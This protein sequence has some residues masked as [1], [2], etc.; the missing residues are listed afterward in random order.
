MTL[1]LYFLVYMYELTLFVSNSN[2][3]FM[4]S[5]GDRFFK[6][7]KRNH[8]HTLCPILFTCYSLPPKENIHFCQVEYSKLR[9]ARWKVG[10]VGDP[11]PLARDNTVLKEEIE[12][13]RICK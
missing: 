5:L 7:M 1:R 12:C 6:T 10:Y 2:F 9:G 13:S 11:T 8:C 4:F 3:Y